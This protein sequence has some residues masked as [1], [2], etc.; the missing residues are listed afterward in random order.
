V[1]Q[2]GQ[3][4]LTLHDVTG[5]MVMSVVDRT[6]DAGNYTVE[7]SAAELA[8]GVYLYRLTAAGQT[9][10]KKLMLVK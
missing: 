6:M 1:P 7:L 8:G 3:V 5:R 10:T 4:S 2:S 9:S